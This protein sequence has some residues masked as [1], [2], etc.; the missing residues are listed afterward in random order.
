MT[1]GNTGDT[2]MQQAIYSNI[3]RD[4]T[5]GKTITLTPANR[6]AS[7]G[8]RLAQKW[9]LYGVVAL[10]LSSGMYGLYAIAHTL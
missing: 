5:L 7:L 2:T 9:D 3:S 1:D 6:W 10:M 8:R 4:I